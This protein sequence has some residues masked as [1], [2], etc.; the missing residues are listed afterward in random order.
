MRA[1]LSRQFSPIAS[2][3]DPHPDPLPLMWERE[4]PDEEARRVKQ[5]S[6]PLIAALLFAVCGGIAA[7]SLQ[8][9]L[10]KFA[11]ES[12]VNAWVFVTVPGLFAALFALIVYQ[13]AERRIERVGQSLTRGLLVAL[14][15][16]FA[17][18]ALAT[19]VWFPVED[20]F[21]WLSTVLLLTGFVGGGPMLLAALVAS[22][23][24]GWLILRRGRAWV[25]KT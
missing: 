22:A 5:I 8:F 20:F 14:L 1:D 17:F 3:A 23:I 15:S 24:F 10:R 11:V 2:A 19:A 9:T 4:Q 13:G 21:S 16:W 6:P 18:S 7:A 12:G 25:L